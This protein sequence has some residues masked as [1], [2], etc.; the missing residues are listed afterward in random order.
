MNIQQFGIIGDIHC[1]ASFLEKAITFLQAQDVET[2]LCTGDI[3]DGV[4]D[5]T[6]DFDKCVALLRQNNVQA[7]L[8]NHDNWLLSDSMRS[9]PKATTLEEVES[10][11]LEYLRTL[12]KTLDFQSPLG[13]VLLCHGLGENDMAK[14]TPDDY[15][16]AIEANFDLQKIVSEKNIPLSL[17]GILTKEW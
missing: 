7:V 8:G 4:G 10:S 16:Y 12:P 13:E 3:A 5:G 2:I 17:V 1:E 6:G 15:G 11:S 14:F 9:L